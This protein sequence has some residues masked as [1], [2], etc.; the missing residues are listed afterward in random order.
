[1]DVYIINM[2]NLTTPEDIVQIFRG[3]DS[4]TNYHIICFEDIDRCPM[5][6]PNFRYDDPNN[7]TGLRTLLNELDGIVEGNKRITFFTANNLNIIDK[8]DALCRP[9]RIDK[10]IEIGYCD[11]DQLSRIFNHYT[12]SNTTL[13]IDEEIPFKITP[14][15]AVKT[16]LSDTSMSSF[17]FTQKLQIEN[18]NENDNTSKDGIL[19]YMNSNRR[20][21]SSKPWYDQHITFETMTNLMNKEF[22]LTNTIIETISESSTLTE[23][24]EKMPSIIWGRSSRI[25][26][27]G[28]LSKRAITLE[29]HRKE[30]IKDNRR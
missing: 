22:T 18:R 3:F 13:V 11:R 17:M 20:K 15:T 8:I 26:K 12:T 10:K 7:A 16:I 27:L 23:L 28:T 24:R 29:K 1:M 6:I 30:F 9:G 19:G 4:I 14:A 5:F 21:I 25:K 2:E